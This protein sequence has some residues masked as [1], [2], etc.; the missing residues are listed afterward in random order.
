[1]AKAKGKVKEENKDEVQEEMSPKDAQTPAAEAADSAGDAEPSVD[2][3][4]LEAKIAKLEEENS[5]LKDQYLRKHADFENYRKRMI[6]EKEEAL[7]FGNGR[8]LED[9]ITIIDD[10]ERAI[11]SS[12]SSQDFE[13]FHSG[14]E[15]IE[16]QFTSMLDKKWGLKRFDSEGQEFNPEK[17]EAI[18]MDQGEGE[19]QIVLEDF[20]KG[21]MLHDRVLRHAKVKIGHSDTIAESENPAESDESEDSENT[22]EENKEDK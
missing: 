17:H 12:E 9:L 11:K 1:M 18:A 4:E 2:V 7:K 15:L 16:K 20:Q 22:T 8:L 6:R 5:D 3:S 21:F 14:I 19:Y 13:S 10:F